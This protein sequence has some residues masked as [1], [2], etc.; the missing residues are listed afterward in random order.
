MLL[1]EDIY[2]GDKC[3]EDALSTASTWTSDE[4][5]EQIQSLK[6]GLNGSSAKHSPAKTAGA[7]VS[8][9]NLPPP[10]LANSF[11]EYT[12]KQKAKLTKN[13]LEKHTKI[14]QKKHYQHAHITAMSPGGP[15]PNGLNY[16]ALQFQPH[17]A[18]SH[19]LKSPLYPTSPYT[20]QPP[21]VNTVPLSILPVGAP[22]LT[23]RLSINSL[24]ITSTINHHQHS[25]SGGGGGQQTAKYPTK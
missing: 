10:Q 20:P 19:T 17:G 24:P 11:A 8:Y 5:D 7:N 12:R 1:S 22:Q 14:E 25:S 9:P 15:T 4:D 6:R 16:N 3:D 23:Q 2:Y 21:N 18:V 13:N